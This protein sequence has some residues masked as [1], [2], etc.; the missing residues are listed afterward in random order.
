[1]DMASSNST[2]STSIELRDQNHSDG[3]QESSD[4]IMKVEKQRLLAVAQL[5]R[6]YK[7]QESEKIFLKEIEGLIDVNDLKSKS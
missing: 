3:D 6:K 2:N 5:L 7:F 1:M 4:K